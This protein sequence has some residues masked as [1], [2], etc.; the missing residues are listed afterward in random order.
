MTRRL[1]VLWIAGASRSGSTLL[2]RLLGTAPGF[3][4]VGEVTNVWARGALENQL[5]S[6][7]HPFRECPFWTDVV[8]EA[9]GAPMIEP[10]RLDDL[11]ALCQHCDYLPRSLFYA[12]PGTG[13]IRVRTYTDALRC[14]HLAI[15]RVSGAEVVV[16]SSKR[17]SYGILL[18][19]I[20]EMRLSCL[21]LVRDSR[22][23]SH[24][25]RRLRRKPE[26]HWEMAFMPTGKPWRQALRWDVHNACAVL[27]G[28]RS[29]QYVRTRYE[30]LARQ[31]LETVN[32]AL[33]ELGFPPLASDLVTHSSEGGL[34]L[35]LPSDHSISGNP[36]RFQSG[37][38]A[39]RVDDEWR[40]AMPQRD[41]KVVTS[42]SWPLLKR[43]GYL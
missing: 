24:S 9:F 2:G 40:T 39:V 41:R 20:H 12:V 14:L 29:D 35:F 27:A 42:L 11:L 6:C 30:D 16:D 33:G 7:G 34:T 8:A 43:Y 31:P 5:C 10:G 3:V 36:M 23:V 28:W 38:V 15:R 13:G 21:H 25:T 26:I 19:R 18:S 4:H 17:P 37:Q 1:D 22:G 32:V